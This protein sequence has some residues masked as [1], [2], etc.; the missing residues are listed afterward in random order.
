MQGGSA[1]N[2]HPIVLTCIG[3]VATTAA[4]LTPIVN[5]GQRA[6]RRAATVAVS[7]KEYG[8]TPSSISVNHGV[9]TFR[10]TNR[11]RIGHDLNVDGKTTPIINPGKTATITVSLKKGTY[12][13]ICTVP[14]HAKLGMRGTLKVK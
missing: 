13:F 14:G 2:R 9:V 6:G 12:T 3:L 11:G 7:G 5:A 8:F 4:V 10:F 1:V